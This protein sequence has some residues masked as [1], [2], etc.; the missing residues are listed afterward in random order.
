MLSVETNVLEG[1]EVIQVSHNPVCI[2][3]FYWEPDS[4]YGTW[5]EWNL[6]KFDQT[7]FMFHQFHFLS[8]KVI[9]HTQTFAV[10]TFVYTYNQRVCMSYYNK[11]GN[12]WKYIKIR[13]GHLSLFSKTW[14]EWCQN[15]G[16]IFSY[17][18]NVWKYSHQ[19]CSGIFLSLNEND[20]MPKIFVAITQKVK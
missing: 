20:H 5:M 11:N 7:N 8:S 10:Y 9:H 13:M 2:I 16:S 3:Q 6:V 1:K 19:V 15:S 14:W 12:F 17:I 18:V 4:L